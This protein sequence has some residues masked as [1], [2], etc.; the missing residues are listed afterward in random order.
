MSRWK[1]L[2]EVE[3]RLE[4]MSAEE[5]RAWLVH[6]REHLQRLRGP[7]LKLG[8]KDLHRFERALERK[9]SEEMA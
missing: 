6:W 5:L 2:E 9:I 3:A 7:A 8:I 1:R 4:D